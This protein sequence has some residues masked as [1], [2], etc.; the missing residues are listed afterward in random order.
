[1]GMREYLCEKLNFAYENSCTIHY[2]TASKLSTLNSKL[3]KNFR[4]FVL[5]EVFCI[6][7]LECG[8][9][10]SGDACM[11]LLVKN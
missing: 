10:L 2:K 1:M 6:F 9:S 4:F 5:L 3:K 8:K 11:T 7:A